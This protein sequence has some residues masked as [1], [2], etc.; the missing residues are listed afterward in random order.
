MY[1]CTCTVAHVVNGFEGGFAATC[2]VLISV[3]TDDDGVDAT[4]RQLNLRHLQKKVKTQLNQALN[5]TG[6]FILI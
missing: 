5:I 2:L 6:R 1:K 4:S 3:V